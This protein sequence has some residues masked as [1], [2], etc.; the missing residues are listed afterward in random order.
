MAAAHT[1]RL[2]VDYVYNAPSVVNVLFL[3][4][5]MGLDS[6]SRTRIIPVANM[7]GTLAFA[8]C[9]CCTSLY[10]AY[11]PRAFCKHLDRLDQGL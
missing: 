2:P 10:D 11:T 7:C 8:M 4:V 6:R 1:L 5:Q 3:E 9:I